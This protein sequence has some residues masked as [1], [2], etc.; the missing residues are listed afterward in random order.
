LRRDFLDY[1]I[2]ETKILSANCIE[3]LAREMPGSGLLR[4]HCLRPFGGAANDVNSHGYDSRRRDIIAGV[5]LGQQFATDAAVRN[6]LE[7]VATRHPS[8]AIAGLCEGWPAN[9]VLDDLFLSLDGSGRAGRLVWPDAIRLVA[10]RG[11]SEAFCRL[12][13]A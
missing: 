10:V 6:A 3:A 13:R 12:V 2:R 1:C 7:A 5:I 9:K 11:G 8:A 4:D